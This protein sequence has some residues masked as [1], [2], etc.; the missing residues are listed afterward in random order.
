MVAGT[1]TGTGDMVAGVDPKTGEPKPGGGGTWRG[2]YV[3]SGTCGVVGVLGV[4][5]VSM[6]VQPLHFHLI[7]TL[8]LMAVLYCVWVIPVPHILCCHLVHCSHSR[9]S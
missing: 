3:N 6:L 7:S 1:G 8:V 5:D 9:A 2:E 4:T